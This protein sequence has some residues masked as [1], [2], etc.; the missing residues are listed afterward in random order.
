M[1]QDESV[2]ASLRTASRGPAAILGAAAV[3]AC[4]ALV[5]L[6]P[7]RAPA[8]AAPPL[9]LDKGVIKR[10]TPRVLVLSALDGSRLSLRLNPRTRVVLNGRTARIADLVP[11]L[12]ASARH[13]PAGVVR[14][15]QA[16]GTPPPPV[17]E[18]RGILEA[19]AADGVVLRRADG[20][21]LSVGVAPTTR[22]VL[23]GVPASLA[24]LRPGL[25]AVIRHRGGAAAISIRAFGRVPVGG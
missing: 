16:V 13:T 7:G 8:A 24:D 11:G 20:G 6:A 19:V 2:R 21:T 22:V 1:I 10:V 15:V 17:T 4:L 3:A 9:V 25:Q 14:Q 23:R 5:L 18:E 12:A